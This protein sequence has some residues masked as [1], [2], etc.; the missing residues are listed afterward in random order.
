M[1]KFFRKKVS[2]PTVSEA[3]EKL[4]ETESMLERKIAYIERKID[5]QDLLVRANAKGDKRIAL[6]ALKSKKKL[7]K[8]C[9]SLSGTL[10]SVEAQRDALEQARMNVEIVGTLSVAASAVKGTFSDADKV[11]DVMDDIAEQVDSCTEISEMLSRATLPDQDDDELLAEIDEMLEQK[12][13]GHHEVQEPN[14]PHV[15]VELPIRAFDEVAELK[16][17]AAA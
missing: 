1:L 14:F 17:W 5:S 7:E 12:E 16:M 4:R 9:E 10:C 15:P 2:T 3:M 13:T 8:K 6:K 11:H